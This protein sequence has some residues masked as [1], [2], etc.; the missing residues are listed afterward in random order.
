MKP[1]EEN[2]GILSER[3]KDLRKNAGLS[4]EKLAEALSLHDGCEKCSAQN[5]SN[6][7]KGVPP[8]QKYINAYLD[9]FVGCTLDYLY[10]KSE[11]PCETWEER[12]NR[13]VQESIDSALNTEAA[14]QSIARSFLANWLSLN[15]YNYARSVMEATDRSHSI[16]FS[17]TA[18]NRKGYR[19]RS[20]IYSKD[21][22]STESKLMK[23]QPDEIMVSVEDL[24]LFPRELLQYTEMRLKTITEHNNFSRME[25]HLF[26][27]DGNPIK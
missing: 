2:K 22:R 19:F 9:Y 21:P 12:R 4:Q 10:G 6:W 11:Y 3:L 5:I 20:C 27:N 15:G 26:D 17:G 16:V 7:E 25:V 14:L 13:Q 18:T 8:S 23:P 1:K 24:H